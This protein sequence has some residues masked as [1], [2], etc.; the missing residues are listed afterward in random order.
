MA[1][2]TG[3]STNLIRSEVWTAQLQAAL[4]DHLTDVNLLVKDMTGMFGDGTQLTIPSVG[5][6]TVRD[7]VEDEDHI[8]DAI[9]KGEIS[10]TITDHK[11]SGTYFTDELKENAH[12]GYMAELMGKVPGMM[13]EALQE[14]YVADVLALANSQSA[15][16]GNAN[17]INGVDHRRVASGTSEVMEIKDFALADHALAKNAPTITGRKAIVDPSVAYRIETLANVTSLLARTAGDMATEGLAKNFKFRYNIMGFDVMT[18]NQ[19]ADANETIG[20]KTTAAGK[21]NI[22]LAAGGDDDKPF[23]GA[24]RRQPEVFVKRND[25][26][27]RDEVGLS[28]RWGLGLYRDE[29]LVVILADTDQVS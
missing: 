22:F 11:Q 6:L 23:M 25:I 19:L 1:N 15:G 9:D 18:S 8:F 29:T 27:H 4:P 5:D 20:A 13:R 17:T 2:L 16:T 26:R 10:L 7:R 3:N 12:P 14:V 21:A 28:A 24:W